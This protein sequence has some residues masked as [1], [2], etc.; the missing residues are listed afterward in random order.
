MTASLAGPQRKV[1]NQSPQPGLPVHSGPGPSPPDGLSKT[2]NLPPEPMR[3][4]NPH[5]CRKRFVLLRVVS[6]ELTTLGGDSRLSHWMLKCHSGPAGP[7][8]ESVSDGHLPLQFGLSS[9]TGS[10][11]LHPSKLS[12]DTPVLRKHTLKDA[13]QREGPRVAHGACFKQSTLFWSLEPIDQNRRITSQLCDPREVTA[14][15]C[16]S[17]SSAVKSGSYQRPPHSLRKVPSHLCHSLSL[18]QGRSCV[19]SPSD[20]GRCLGR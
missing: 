19:S 5:H 9:L 3:P 15:L 10:C 1:R 12:R 4:T 17:V 7:A 14:P 6:A 2:L 13:H 18:P 8:A 20:A 16:A 11:S